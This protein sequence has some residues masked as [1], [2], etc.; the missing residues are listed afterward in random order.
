MN[1]TMRQRSQLVRAAERGLDR[2]PSGNRGD[3]LLCV[4]CAAIAVFFLLGVFA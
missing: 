1:Q 4:A 3:H 2:E